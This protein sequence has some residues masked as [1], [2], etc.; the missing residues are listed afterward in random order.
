MRTSIYAFRGHTIQPTIFPS[1]TKGFLS[2]VNR[3]TIFPSHQY[4]E[5]KPIHNVL[6]QETTL[7]VEA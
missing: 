7:T 6:L 3:G 5:A 2:P 1:R 4:Q